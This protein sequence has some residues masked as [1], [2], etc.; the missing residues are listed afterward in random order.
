MWSA[1]SCM[2]C[3]PA[4]GPKSAPIA[5]VS[6]SVFWSRLAAA[7]GKSG[8]SVAPARSAATAS[9][10]C[11]PSSRSSSDRSRHDGW[12]SFAAS[13]GGSNVAANVCPMPNAWE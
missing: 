11:S 5:A 1:H 7:A 12:S 9:A 13:S 10:M 4:A 8:L 2:N 6:W 3:W